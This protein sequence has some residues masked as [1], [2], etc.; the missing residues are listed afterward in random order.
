MS[1][2]YPRIRLHSEDGVLLLREG[3]SLCFYIHQHHS[4]VKDLV[5]RALETYREAVGPQALGLYA[6]EET[7]E[8]LDHAGWE[9][10]REKLL[11]P[12]GAHLTLRDPLESDAGYHFEY[13]GRPVGEPGVRRFPGTVCAMEFWLPTEFLEQRGPERVQALAL[14]LAGPLPFCSGHAGLAFHGE[15][16]LLGVSEAI[17]K[18]GF[19]YP[20]LDIV[21]L[22]RLA[23]QLGTK[24][25]SAHW[26]TF[27]GQPVLGALDGADTLRSRLS[28]PGT[29]VHA[30]DPE[31][32]VVILGTWPEAGDSGHGL[33]LPAYRELAHVL[34]P[35]TFFEEHGF[36][37]GF[38]SLDRRRWER[39]FLDPPSTQSDEG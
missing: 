4:Q 5:L 32:A 25:R 10:V 36:S 39:R 34:E 19:L 35:W 12:W 16:T 31:R 26:M 28:S 37:L 29:Q 27:L 15:L 23:S 38:S 22:E 21:R 14:E 20:G 30:L 33:F 1:A 9:R 13:C 11:A 3:L 7:W 8:P 24:V 2:H 18:Y 6:A 17:R